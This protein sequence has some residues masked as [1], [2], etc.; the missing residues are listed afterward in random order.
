MG[1]SHV[2]IGHVLS[3]LDR[4]QDALE[5]YQEGLRIEAAALGEEHPNLAG[6]HEAIG[7]A[8][9]ALD[10][11]D[12]GIQHLRR[13]LSIYAKADPSRPDEAWTHL[14]LGRA[15]TRREGCEPALEH[16][17]RA[18][19]IWRES[20]GDTHPHLARPLAAIGQCAAAPERAAEAHGALTKVAAANPD[21]PV[22]AALLA[23]LDAEDDTA[24]DAA[25]SKLTD[26]GE[27]FY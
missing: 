21:S 18:A 12:D 16:F 20:F 14:A 27:W 9:L 5:H 4:P 17:D 10:R 6:T 19:A 15:V 26:M 13:S 1:S 22:S 11:F 8:L 3:G 7:S 24:V 25:K 23:L 2:S